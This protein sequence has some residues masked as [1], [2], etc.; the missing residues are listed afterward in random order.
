[1]RVMARHTTFRF[2][3]APTRAQRKALER[4]TGAARFVYNQSLRVVIDRLEARKAAPAPCDGVG[5][6]GRCWQG[7][8]L[9]TRFRTSSTI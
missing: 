5:R 8:K 7:T 4:H 1:M 2:T 3:L 6:K 9:S